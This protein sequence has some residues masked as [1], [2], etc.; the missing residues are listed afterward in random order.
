MITE[1]R[2]AP[3]MGMPTQAGNNL[4]YGLVQKAKSERELLSMIDKL[5]QKLGGKYKDAKD[6]LITRAAI[7]FFNNKGNKGEQGKADRNVFVQIK[8][9]ADLSGGSEIK[10]DDKSKVKISK[11][12]AENIIKN[13]EKVKPQQR[14]QVQKSMQKDK[15]SFLKFLK[16]LNV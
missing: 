7:D 9:A 16:I 14:L 8:G 12:D 4:L 1:G 5:A 2:R 11:R 6:E 3:D 15:R 13:L 10:L